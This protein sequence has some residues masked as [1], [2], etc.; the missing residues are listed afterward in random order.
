MGVAARL[1]MGTRPYLT[2]SVTAPGL[3]ITVSLPC[4]WLNRGRSAL[5]FLVHWETTNKK[6]AQGRKEVC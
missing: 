6:G 3:I 5:A 2:V 4:E 1:Q